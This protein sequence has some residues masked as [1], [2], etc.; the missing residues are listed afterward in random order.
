MDNKETKGAGNPNQPTQPN[1]PNQKPNGKRR[2][3]LYWVYAILFAVL[4]GVNFFGRGSVTPQ[5]DIDQG[6]LVEMLQKEEIAKIELINKEDAEI[7]L[8]QKGLSHYFPD[9][10]A[11]SEGTTSTPNYFHP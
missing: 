9:V 11:G 4:I 6:K 10:K 3:N 2:F 1:Q 5:E 8:N 7:F